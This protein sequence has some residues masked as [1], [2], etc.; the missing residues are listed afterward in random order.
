MLIDAL[1][2]RHFYPNAN[3]RY[4]AL[5]SL[6]HLRPW[7]SIAVSMGACRLTKIL[8]S[9][10]TSL[11]VLLWKWHFADLVWQLLYYY[12]VI[13]ARQEKIQAGRATSFTFLMN[14]KKRLI[15]KIAEKVPKK[16][17]EGAFMVCHVSML[18]GS[19]IS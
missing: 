16:Y 6:P 3:L 19:M 8:P 9:K 2:A 18:L 7:R 17:R 5:D 10:I 15:G 1:N 14:D 4:P 11:I 13:I 12:F